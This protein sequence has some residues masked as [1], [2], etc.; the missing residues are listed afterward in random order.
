MKGQYYK[1]FYKII[2][3]TDNNG[4]M[5]IWKRRRSNELIIVFSGIGPASFNYVNALKHSD[6]D[7]LFIK[8]SW[9]D[10]VSYYWFENY[11]NY[12]ELHTQQLIERIVKKGNYKK[13]F[14]VG[15]SKGGTAAIYY[16]LLNDV[17]MIF[18]GACQ[19][20]VGSYLAY[21]QYKEHPE[22]WENMMGVKPEKSLVEALDDKLQQLIIRKK[23]C[24]TTIN[25][26]YSTKEHTYQEH[27]LPLISI[28]DNNNI[29]HYDFVES[30]EQH[31][32]I[33]KYF[34]K[35]I[36]SYFVH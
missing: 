27:I 16:G 14:T 13:I 3:K 5:Y 12:P 2:Q 8:D 36:T 1:L 30:F 29:K 4:V 20:L 6:K 18:A 10:G 23:N 32:M 31:S 19:F 7:L 35:F 26:M 22:Q 15:S 9:A 11:N 28:L 25:L 34:K 24:K 33:G 21:H 17:D